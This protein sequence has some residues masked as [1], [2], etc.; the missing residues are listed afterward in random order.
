MVMVGLFLGCANY[1]LSEMFRQLF[2]FKPMAMA[3][4]AV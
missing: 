3:D 2:K 4:Y 1:L